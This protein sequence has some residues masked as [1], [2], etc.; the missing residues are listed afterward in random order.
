MGINIKY[1]YNNAKSV[2][3]NNRFKCYICGS[4]F[5]KYDQLYKHTIKYHKDLLT[6]VTDIDKYLYDLRN[7]GPHICMICK[8]NPCVWNAKKKHYSRFCENKECIDKFKEKMSKGKVDKYGT[9]NLLKDPERQA[10]MLAN[11]KISHLYTF[12]DGTTINCVGKY[13]LDF[14]HFCE[15]ELRLDSTDIIPSPS[16]TYIK[17][18]DPADKKDHTYMPDFYMPKY[19]LVIEIK[20]GSK[21]PIDA[22][23]KSILKGKA[24]V[25]AN[26]Y[27]YIKIVDKKYDDFV[28]L[29]DQFNKKEY[30]ESSSDKFI[31][32]IPE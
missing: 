17:Y 27:N 9:D 26:K 3:S 12:K 1:F 11:R 23:Y 19:N 31:F 22:K 2:K 4:R 6:D 8:I 21:Y 30:C 20:D 10:I 16:S 29:L 25:K 14:I 32:I 5:G 18:Y 28:N 15:F 13:E 7:P 24:V